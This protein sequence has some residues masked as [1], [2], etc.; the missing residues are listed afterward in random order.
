MEDFTPALWVSTQQAAAVSCNHQHKQHCRTVQL[1]L[2]LQPCHAGVFARAGLC[3]DSM[4]ACRQRHPAAAAQVWHTGF[5]QINSAYEARLWSHP[6]C[7][8]L[9]PAHRSNA[10]KAYGPWAEHP[11][12]SSN[13]AAHP[14][15]TNS[16]QLHAYR[17]H[18]DPS[19]SSCHSDPSHSSAV[20]GLHVG[21]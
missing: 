4:L 6:G 15:T 21:W 20:A 13:L 19:H 8:W 14:I 18:S 16:T 5:P 17:C 9:L 3:T 7:G 1:L 2:Q 12:H 11:L 10:E